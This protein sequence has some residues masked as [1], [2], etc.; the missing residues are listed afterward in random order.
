MILLISRGQKCWHVSN[1]GQETFESAIV[2][3]IVGIPK[4]GRY[5]VFIN[6]VATVNKTIYRFDRHPAISTH[7][8][9][10]RAKQ[11]PADTSV[12]R[13]TTSLD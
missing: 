2:P 3:M 4:L 7:P 5:V 11:I 9:T 10:S 13:R 8:M 1:F 12:N 6:H